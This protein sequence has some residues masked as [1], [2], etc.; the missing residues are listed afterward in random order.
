[1]AVKVDI[2]DVF[3]EWEVESDIRGRFRRSGRMFIPTPSGEFPWVN[4]KTAGRHF[5]VLLPLVKAMRQPNDELP[6][7]MV[8]ISDLERE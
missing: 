8:T 7:G 4:T 3:V 5:E 6:I 2:Q 1:M